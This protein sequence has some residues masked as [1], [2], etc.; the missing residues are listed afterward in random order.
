MNMNEVVELRSDTFTMPDEGMM[1]AMFKAK[2]GDDVFGEDPTVNELE[3]LG[4]KLLGKEAALFCPSGTMCNQI[5]IKVNSIAPGDLICEE[6]SHVYQYEGGGIAFTSGLSTTLLSSENG[7]ISADQ[8]KEAI[9]PDDLHKAKTQLV[10][11]ENT[12][13]RGGGSCYDIKEVERIKKL[14]DENKLRMHL[15]GARLFNAVIAKGY[16]VAEFSKFFDSVSICLSKGLGAPVGSLLVSTEETIYNA[17][18]F[19]KVL[20]GGMRQAGYLA[21]AG[22]YA[23]ENNIERLRDDHAKAGEISATLQQLSWVS[24]VFPAETNILVFQIVDDLKVE[25][26]ID[27]LKAKNI[28]AVPFGK[29]KIRMVTHMGVSDEMITKVCKELSG[30]DFS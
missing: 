30:L 23:L 19:R 6:F 12:H 27:A 25:Q 10:V 2:V 21:A 13:N 20:G 1:N 9:N 26:V 28:L 15:D 4:A 24:N 29:Q 17:R 8:I 3:E 11:L 7:L 14:C 18:R 5:G 16:Q 22:I